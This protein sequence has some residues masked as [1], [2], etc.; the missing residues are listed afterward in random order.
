[1]RCNFP[2]C[3]DALLNLH[4]LSGRLDK[5][6]HSV[7]LVRGLALLLAVFV[8][9]VQAAP[10]A[11]NG[12]MLLHANDSL[13]QTPQP[14]NGIWHFFP[15]RW[16]NPDQLAAV[17]AQAQT[18]AVPSTWQSTLAHPQPHLGTYWLE[19]L[20]DSPMTQ[21]PAIYF[22]RF[23][24]ASEIY[25]FRDGEPSTSA[26]ARDG[27]PGLTDAAEH[28]GS[29]NLLTTLSPLQPGRYHLLVQQSNFNFRAGGLCGAVTI[30]GSAV[31]A[32]ARSLLVVKNTVIVTLL[33]GLALGVLVL[34]SQDGEK[35][36]PWLALV[37]TSCALLIASTG[38]LLDTLLGPH[39]SS[40]PHWRFNLCFIA[41]M[42]IP[43]GLL[44][45]FR[46]TF[47]VRTPRGLCTVVLTVPALLITTL[48]IAPALIMPFP[49]VLA[50]WV[51]SQYVLAYSVLF[52]ACRQRRRHTLLIA[53]ANIPLLFA[54]AYDYHQYFHHGAIEITTPYALAFLI[55]VH[56]VL[57]T[58]K[59]GTAHQ[60]A[61]RLSTHLQDEVEQR[62]KELRE[63]NT[64]LEQ[65]QIALQRAN[66]SLHLLSITDGLT[67][68]HNR[69]YFE[70][71]FEQE[72][73]RC[74]RQGLALS[75][76][77][78]DADHFKKLNDS[79]GHLTGDLC[80][81]AIAQEIQNHFKRA[82]ELVARYGGEE[83]IVLLP[84]TNQSKAVAVAEGLR[85]AIENLIV[86]QTEQRY[87]ITISVG[88]STTTPAL[89]QQA[90]QLLATADA[91]LYE[92][93]DAGR[94]RVHSIPL[95]S[96]R[97]TMAQQ[98]LHL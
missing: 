98:Q 93:K 6:Q 71:Q 17:A 57:Y 88:V 11:S 79:A 40:Q 81:R 5:G 80:L 10:P 94:N 65:A 3:P 89:E 37:F 91:A 69:M 43:P 32:H 51:F 62:T 73:R 55:V 82:G 31:Q 36:A 72:W 16:I 49:Q 58:L 25:F 70:Q 26:L 42:W 66:E 9:L 86:E 50:V 2:V 83:F 27:Q 59:L 92:A 75:V 97:R 90:S 67:Q 12:E 18:I 61:A 35:T 4:S 7:M 48:L 96:P 45:L 77:M 56:G 95:L 41:L 46:D 33:L 34:S 60:L 53:L 15:G 14:L 8:G 85:I 76:L 23:C 87:R 21:A 78:I 84:D 20:V 22:E 19:M 1:M 28:P 29:G 24:A 52:I 68:V 38:G 54:M 47:G 74:A 64:K 63:K 39:H 30:G 44:M 13:Q